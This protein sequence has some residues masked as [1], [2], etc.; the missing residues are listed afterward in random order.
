MSNSSG[1]QQNDSGLSPW[2]LKMT[3]HSGFGQVTTILNVIGQS[4][5]HRRHHQTGRHEHCA[6]LDN[7]S[8][9]QDRGHQ[10]VPS[11]KYK[12]QS[13]IQQNTDPQSGN[14][15]NSSSLCPWFLTHL[16]NVF[17]QLQINKYVM[18]DI[19]SYHHNHHHRFK[20]VVS[21]LSTGRTVPPIERF[22]STLECWS[23]MF[24]WPDALPDAKPSTWRVQVWA[25]SSWS[26]DV[27]GERNFNLTSVADLMYNK[28]EKI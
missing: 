1:R 3:S 18:L 25:G 15:Q 14:C 20:S 16:N 28:F 10:H 17:C 23:Y 4:E 19:T 7:T 5:S 9:W 13:K 24:Y 12:A 8:E 26:E 2:Q 22:Y 27:D 11:T 21:V 6:Q